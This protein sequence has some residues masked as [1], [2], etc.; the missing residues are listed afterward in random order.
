MSPFIAFLKRRPKEL[1]R[2]FGLAS[3]LILPE[4]LLAVDEAEK[5]PGHGGGEQQLL[6]PFGLPTV[7]AILSFVV[8]LAVL[9][10]KLFPPIL[11]AMD[12]RAAEIRDALNAAEKARAEAQQ[13]M[14]RHQSDLDK[15]RKEAAS[16]IEEGKADAVEVKESIIQT[17]RKDAE[18]ITARSRREI[19]QAKITALEDIKRESIRLSFDIASRLIRKNLDPKEH[20]EL[21]QEQ[22]RELPVA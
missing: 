4:L 14:E 19:E 1:V 10:K 15:A 12:K 9:L 7:W 5:A 18:E 13:M 8:V 3:T 20:Q 17:A 22:I 16:I 2:L 6:A 21:I 11:Q